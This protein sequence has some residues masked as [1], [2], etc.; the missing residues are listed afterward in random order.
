MVVRVGFSEE[1][2]LKL[3]LEGHVFLKMMGKCR[4]KHS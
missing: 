4:A 2:T 3:K 1:L